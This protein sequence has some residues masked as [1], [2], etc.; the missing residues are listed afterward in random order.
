MGSLTSV[1][2]RRFLKLA[3][4]AAVVSGSGKAMSAS[5][6]KVQIVI[7]EA[8]RIASG[9]PAM[10]AVSQLRQA[11]TEKQIVSEIVSSERRVDNCR[12]VILVSGN[13]SQAIP[14]F[15]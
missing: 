9:Q 8:D 15:S 6:G 13:I 3:G 11:F 1:P 5:D 14:G 12:L 10:W 2:R 7:R 4:A